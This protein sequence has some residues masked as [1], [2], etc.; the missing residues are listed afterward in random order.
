[1]QGI[2]APL[3]RVELIGLMNAIA[4]AEPRPVMT[5]DETELMRRLWVQLRPIQT[6]ELEAVRRIHGRMKRI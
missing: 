1:M 4:S 6:L 2:L 5:P 3:E